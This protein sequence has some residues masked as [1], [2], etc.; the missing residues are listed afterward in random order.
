MIKAGMARLWGMQ[1][2]SGGLSYW[3]GSTEDCLWG[4]AYAALCLL[5]ASEAGYPVESGLTKPL[6]KY[7][8]KQLRIKDDET[9]DNN[10]KALICRVLATFGQVPLGWMTRLTEQ[11][12]TLDIA[13]QAHLAAAFFAA[14]RRDQALSLLPDRLSDKSAATSTTGR[15]TSQTCQEATLLSVLLHLNP[16]HLLIPRLVTRVE[17]ARSDGRWQSTLNNASCVSALSQYQIAQEGQ[18][19]NYKRFQPLFF[20]YKFYSRPAEQYNPESTYLT[21][22][23]PDRT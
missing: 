21:S 22:L 2:R 11:P 10:T 3:P 17:K 15:L 5:E 8:D 18:V 16:D 1:T 14:G 13:G 6:A 19:Q 9:L 4:T 12:D 7:L 20:Q 23:P